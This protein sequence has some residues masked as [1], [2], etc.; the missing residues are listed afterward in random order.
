MDGR[1]R[2]ARTAPAPSRAFALVVLV[3]ALV[4]LAP[5]RAPAATLNGFVRSGD[6]GEA[7]PGAS[8]SLPALRRGALTNQAGFYVIPDLPAGP[9]RVT[10]TLLGYRT[11]TR[12]VTLPEKGAVSLNLE[13]ALAPPE[14]QGVLVKPGRTENTIEPST[15]R[16]ESQQLQRLTVAGEADLFRAV[17]A[18]PGVS[19]LSDF[20]AGLYVRGGSPDQNL[21]LLDDIDVYNPSH[22]FGF[23]STFNV[24]AVNTVDLQK[25]AYPAQYGGRLSSLLDVHNRDGNRKRLSGVLRTGLIASSATLEG[26]WRHGSWMASG[27]A[28]HLEALAKAVQVDLP[29]GFSDFQSRFNWDPTASDRTS[30]SYYAGRDKLDW[31]TQGLLLR[32]GWGNE[33]WSGQ[34]THVFTPQLFSHSVLG[35]SRF[36]SDEV[37]EFADFGFHGNNSVGDW[38]FKQSLAWSPSAA[39]KIDLGGEGKWLDFTYSS[40]AGNAEPLR[41]DYAGTYSSV[42]LQDAW[43]ISDRWRL[44]TGLRAD[45][46]EPGGYWRLDPR[47]ALER[48]L[49]ERASAHLAY[50]RYHQFLNLVSQGGVGVAE[51]W[52]PVDA[53]LEPGQADHF[54]AGLQVSPHPDFDVSLEGYV[55]PYR[56]VVEYSAEFTR[57][58]VEPTARM[59]DLFNSGSGRASGLDL[60]VRDRWAGF[61]GWLGYS[62]GRSVRTIEGVN[63]GQSFLA[64]YDRRHQLVLVQ[65]R[66]LGRRWRANLTFHYG[67]GQ[68]LTLPVGRVTVVDATGRSYD[69]VVERERNTSRLPDY[70]RLDLAVGG[71][72]HPFGWTLEPELQIVNAYA[73]RN[74]WIRTYDTSKNPAEFKDVTQ[75]PFLPTINIKVEF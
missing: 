15:L 74:V 43:R 2:H 14:M 42:Y 29:Y 68:P 60:Y 18:L 38:S 39:H 22:L 62:L 3:L 57:S 66:P 27:R 34:W 54:I 64:D 16:L 67:T 47:I 44:Q 20:S 30:L 19:T 6:N 46:Y 70:H 12:E 63:F 35:R 53:T 33:T 25:S 36:D 17:Q 50:G 9:V 61:E 45:H 55:K 71:R 7:L 31:D 75:L 56:N 4:L 37:F 13:L 51:S 23:F 26:P 41:F 8:V 21:I 49:G 72:W 59:S 58:L 52:F 1:P 73:R 32:L 69:V 65:S 28:T 48:E 11:E 24:D 40:R 10:Y 5:A